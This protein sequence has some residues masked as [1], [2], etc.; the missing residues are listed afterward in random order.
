[1]R[2]LAEIGANIDI[3]VT[4]LSNPAFELSRPVVE[5][6]DA[7]KTIASAESLEEACQLANKD[8]IALLAKEYGY[9]AIDAHLLSS[10]VG[11]VEISWVVNPI[12][13]VKNAVPKE[14][15]SSPF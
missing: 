2:N 7:W 11:G 3:T 10:L 5:T 13:T 15:L 14:Y 6:A 12:V 9:D 4:V 8:V 1:M